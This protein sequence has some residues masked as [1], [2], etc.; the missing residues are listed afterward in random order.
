MS[1]LEIEQIKKDMAA[2]K[3][4]MDE[5]KALE[6]KHMEEWLAA[7]R[8]LPQGPRKRGFTPRGNRF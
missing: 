4:K 8:L 3:L 7:E 5:L 6:A 2:S 1:L